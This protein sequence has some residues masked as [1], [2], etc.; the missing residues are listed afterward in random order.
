MGASLAH[1]DPP[2][3][4]LGDAC[5]NCPLV[6]NIDQT[7]TDVE[8]EATGASVVGDDFGDACDDDDDNDGFEDDVEA[9]LGTV[10]LDNCPGGPPGPGGDAW[11]FDN[12]IDRYVTVVEDILTYAG[13]ISP[14]PLHL[15]DRALCGRRM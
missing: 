11:P 10:A 4:S 1:S 15:E 7:N 6:A 8:L 2:G 13:K 9:Y 5:D 12:N 14:D 3:D